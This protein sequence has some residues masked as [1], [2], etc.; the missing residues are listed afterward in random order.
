MRKHTKA[1]YFTN[2]ENL[3]KLFYFIIKGSLSLCT[4]YQYH[5]PS[6]KEMY[7]YTFGLHPCLWHRASKTS[8]FLSDESNKDVVL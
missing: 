7:I 4:A 2:I 3:H 1:D 8:N 6:L 5:F